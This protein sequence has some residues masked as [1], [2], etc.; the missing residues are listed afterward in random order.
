MKPPAHVW[1]VVLVIVA[2]L[3]ALSVLIVVWDLSING[4]PAEDRPTFTLDDEDA[5]FPTLAVGAQLPS[6]EEC[7]ERVRAA[8][9]ERE[10]RPENSVANNSTPPDEL[11]LPPW[12]SFWASPVNHTFVPRIDGQFTGSTDE[13]I[14]WGACKWGID[15]NVVRAMAVSETS[16]RQSFL[17]DLEN[18]PALCVGDYDLPCPTSFGLLQIKHVHRPGSY[19]YSQTSTAFNV[20]YGLAVIRGCYEGY[21][22][23]LRS[24]YAAGDLW[25]CAGWHYSGE[26][27]DALAR[28]YIDASQGHYRER[29]W[30]Y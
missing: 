9:L 20:D 3:A 8:G 29:E 13:I 10:V 4:R 24:G 23:Y 22:T 25:G 1:R 19:P 12:P 30:L 26:W 21:I 16:W 15:A 2:V 6:G 14:A 5:D 7:G 27:Y 28:R 17:G 11:V 18:D